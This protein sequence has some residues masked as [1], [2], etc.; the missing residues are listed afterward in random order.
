MKQPSPLHP[1]GLAAS[2][3]L[4]RFHVVLVEPGDPLNVGSVARAMSNLGFR[5]LH[6]V[7]PPRWDAARAAQTACWATDVLEGAQVHATLAEALAPMQ[8]VVGFT[9][10]HGRN[11]PRHVLLPAWVAGLAAAPPL[12]RALL[13]GPEDNGLSAEHIS[14]CRWLVRIPSAGE[15]PSFNLAQAVLLT[16][17]EL[18][19]LEWPAE[20]AP[21]APRAREGDLQQLERLVEE[22]ARRSGFYGKGTPEP[23]PGLVKHLLR[24]IEPDTR[25]LPVLL[26]LFDRINRTLAGRS[27]LQPL[28]G[29]APLWAEPPAPDGPS[30]P[31]APNGPSGPPQPPVPDLPAARAPRRRPGGRR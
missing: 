13:F 9:A 27:P 18:S 25:E 22:A 28:P 12:E 14:A 30:G 16:L 6:L 7:A 10:R 11:R 3:A 1:A 29:D 23:L 20:A 26:G 17:F 21:P 4:E 8:E 24:R 19:R 31:P 2:E 5:R 15:N